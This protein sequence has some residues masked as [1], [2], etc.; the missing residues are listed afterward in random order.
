[1]KTSALCAALALCGIT[2]LAQAV[3]TPPSTY[4][5]LNG[6][7][8][9]YNY[10]DESYNGSGCTTCDN[11]PL[12]GGRGDLTDG[13]IATD[14]WYVTEAPAGPGPYVGWVL[15]PIIAFHWNAPVNINSVTVHADDSDGAGGV[16][17]PSAIIVN[18]IPYNIAEPP[19]SLP[20]SFT[21]NGIGFSG[22]DLV[23][24]VQ[25]KNAWVFVS[26]VEFDAAPVPEP[27]SSAMLLGGLGLLGMA[28]RRRRQ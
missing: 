10:W 23:L 24:Q 7:T 20:F 19:G 2:T 12:T 4:T 11:A 21:A 13:V 18:G 17:A 16:S 26:E 1:M 9:S 25:R 5:M 22:T 15:D 6:N 3:A 8:G 27:A 14:N 28:A